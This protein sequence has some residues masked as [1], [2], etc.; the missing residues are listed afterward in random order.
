QGAAVNPT[1]I[2]T[3]ARRLAAGPPDR[4]T[5]PAADA[6]LL[7]RFLDRHDESAFEALVARHLPAVRAVC[8]SLLRDPNDADD[9]VQATFLVLVRRAAAV[10]DR[11][12]RG[13]WLGRVEGRPATQTRAWHARRSAEG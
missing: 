7:T 4:G 1:R 11:E 2:R 5:P 6:D 12:A 8:R 13:A 9:A 10:R 3:V